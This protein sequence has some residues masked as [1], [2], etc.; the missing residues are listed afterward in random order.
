MSFCLR[1]FGALF[2][3]LSSAYAA[4]LPLHH[5]TQLSLSLS[6]LTFH[7]VEHDPLE[8]QRLGGR[9]GSSLAP[10]PRALRVRLEVPPFLR[11]RAR[12]FDAARV[13]HG[14]EVHVDEVVEVGQVGRRDGIAGAV[15][16]REGVEERVERALHQL[17]ER[18]LDRVLA[19]AAEHR[20]LEDVRDALAV[21]DGRAEH[22]AKGLV[23]VVRGDAGDDLGSGLVVD[24]EADVAARGGGGKRERGGS[25]GRVRRGE[26][27]R[28]EL[29]WP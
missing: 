12:V 9:R 15:R 16:V 17:D 23:L 4:A 1:S 10:L 28:E 20:V 21:V 29:C 14:V 2:V 25:K 24:V 8:P 3:F 5:A 6:L 22:R 18:L 13:Q 26:K 27:R 11:K 19:A 7:L